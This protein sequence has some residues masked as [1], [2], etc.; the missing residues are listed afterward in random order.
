ML[1]IWLFFA[2][3]KP[4]SNFN[5]E[6]ACFGLLIELCENKH[7]FVS[8]FYPNTY[9]GLV[10]KVKKKTICRRRK[11]GRVEKNSVCS[12]PAGPG[13]RTRDLL[14]ARRGSPTAPQGGCSDKQAFPC[15]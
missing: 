7:S 5:V 4:Q 2:E 1:G 3:R 12:A 11:E 8:V 13:A 10:G 6:I 9:A 14:R 15:L